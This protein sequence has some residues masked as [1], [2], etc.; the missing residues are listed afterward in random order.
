METL[1]ALLALCAGN[2]LL[3]GGSQHKGPVSWL[4][5]LYYTAVAVVPSWSLGDSDC[6]GWRRQFPVMPV[7]LTVATNE[8]HHSDIIM[9]TT[10]SQTTSVLI[11][12]ST[13]CSGVDQRTHQRSASLAFVRGIDRWPVDS[14]HKGPLT[15]KMFPYDDVIMNVNGIQPLWQ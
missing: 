7:L 4:C 13:V 6:L 15:R 10:V 1:S 2:P 5:S 11:V 9:S 12:C 3:T 8:R 14:P